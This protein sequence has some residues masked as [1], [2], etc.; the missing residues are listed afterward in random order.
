MG[1]VSAKGA[2]TASFF[3]RVL[4]G[5]GA[6]PHAVEDLRDHPDDGQQV[7]VH[8]RAGLNAPQL[9]EHAPSCSRSAL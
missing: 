6:V 8:A 7:R 9:L 4:S 5:R 2:E 1:A 3:A